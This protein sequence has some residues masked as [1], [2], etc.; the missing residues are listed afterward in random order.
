MLKTLYACIIIQTACH[1]SISQTEG[2]DIL[3]SAP[4]LCL[5][6]RTVDLHVL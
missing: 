5:A 3:R 1:L 4:Q 6:P 2:R